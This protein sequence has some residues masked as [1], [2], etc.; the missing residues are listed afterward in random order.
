VIQIGNADPDQLVRALDPLPPDAPVVIGHI[1]PAT[2]V[3]TAMDDQLTPILDELDRAAL[4][5]FPRW[6]PGAS[7]VSGAPGSGIM[8]IR[9]LAFRYAAV[10]NHFGPFLADL[11][12]RAVRARGT[13]G[14]GSQVRRLRADDFPPEI[15]AAGLARAITASHDRAAV[16]VLLSVPVGFS[17]Q[18]EPALVAAAEWLARHGGFQIWLAGAP[19]R[20]VERVPTIPVAVPTTPEVRRVA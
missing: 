18:S 16:A 9:A 3:G 6:L 7:V 17:A 13:Q 1:I 20:A 11:A 10:T 15:R 12:E 8:A 5:L 14:R 19:L 4:D 2:S